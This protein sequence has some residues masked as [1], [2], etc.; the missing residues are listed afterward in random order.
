MITSP[1]ITAIGIYNSKI[2]AKNIEVSRNRVTPGFELELAAEEGGVSYIDDRSH[3]ITRDLLI[4]AKPG[5]VRH[6]RFPFRCSYVHLRVTDGALYELLMELPT[7][8]ITQQREAYAALFKKL[9]QCQNGGDAANTVLLHSLLMELVYTLHCETIAAHTPYNVEENTVIPTT[10]RYIKEHL[11]EDLRLETV[12]AAVHLSPIHFHNKF[13]GAVGTTLRDYV[14][15]QRI[16]KALD[17][18]MTTD[19]SVTEIALTCGFSSQSYFSSVF[20]RRMQ[21]TP[22]EY[23]RELNSR[24]EI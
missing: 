6:T 1:E 24:Y 4:C 12:A 3:P 2:A 21:K 9:I 7:F 23:L 13:K 18:L 5:Q 19:R 14:E 22:R 10:L 17:L 15:E 8:I 20:K 16:K 11:T